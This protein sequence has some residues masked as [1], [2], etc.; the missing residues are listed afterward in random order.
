MHAYLYRFFIELGIHL[1][2]LP[3]SLR[4]SSI[5]SLCQNVYPRERLMLLITAAATPKAARSFAGASL[6]KPGR[7]R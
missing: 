5:G 2:L 1:L 3:A 6:P 4:R 7:M